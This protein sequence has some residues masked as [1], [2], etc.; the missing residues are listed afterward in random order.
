MLK[1]KKSE[2]EEIEDKDEENSPSNDGES[3]HKTQK[4]IPET[5][6]FEDKDGKIKAAFHQNL[7]FFWSWAHLPKLVHG[8]PVVPDTDRN[9]KDKMT[10]F[11]VD[12][13]G[14]KKL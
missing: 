10:K 9:I 5:V 14:K 4:S 13:F 8:I 12:C 2:K 3:V 11:Q 7:I 6:K 1:D